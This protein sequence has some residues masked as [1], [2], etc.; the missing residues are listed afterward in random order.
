MKCPA[1]GYIR[2]PKDNQRTSPQN[3]YLHSMFT[4]IGDHLD[5]GQAEAK[6]IY[7]WLFCVRHTSDLDTAGMA[8]FTDM[9]RADMAKP[10][11]LL[12][13]RYQTPGIYIPA[14]NEPPLG[15]E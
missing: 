8:R 9:V 13:S 7:K 12:N 15:D 3:R 6:A 11:G 1:C 2:K 4:M 14:P 10:D 5:I